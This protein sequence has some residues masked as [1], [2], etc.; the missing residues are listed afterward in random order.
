MVLSQEV[1]MLKGRID[2]FGGQAQRYGTQPDWNED[3]E[4]APLAIEDEANVDERR[5]SVDCPRRCSEPGSRP[6][7]HRACRPRASAAWADRGYW[8]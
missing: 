2:F 8:S 7:T 3:G 4:L 6:K 5:Q 1:A